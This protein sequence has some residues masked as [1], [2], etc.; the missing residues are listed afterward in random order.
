MTNLQNPLDLADVAEMDDPRQFIRNGG[1]SAFQCVVILICVLIQALDGFNVLVVAYT[2]SP[3]AH[4]WNL[5]PSN[6]GVLFSA[7]PLGMA[8]GFTVI[9]PLGDR[10]GRKPILL[11]SL[12]AM[13]LGMLAS[14]FARNVSDLLAMRALTGVGIA[15]ALASVN[16]IVAEYSSEKRR[17]LAI[18]LMTIGYPLG[19]MLGG[20]LSIYL[21]RVF[22]WRAVYAFGASVALALLPCVLVW[23]PE[24][25][26]YLMER[27]PQNALQKTNAI[28]RKMGHPSLA[29]LP[30]VLLR[31]NVPGANVWTIFKQPYLPATLAASSAYF[32]VSITCYFLLN[33][34]PRL[35]TERGFSLAA[36]ISGSLLMSIAGIVGGLFFGFYGSVLGARRLG[37]AIMV[38]LFVATVLFG[39]MPGDKGALSAEC[40]A[41]GFCLFTS[42]TVLLAVVPMAFPS[43]VRATGVGFAMGVGR[44][45]SILGPLLAGMLIANGWARVEYCIVMAVP[46]LVAAASLYWV[47][48]PD[49][50]GAGYQETL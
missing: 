23:L 31:D 36:G 19:A 21:I 7:G 4:E 38:G 34:T 15:C 50:P 46:M 11:L 13:A 10:L 40:F 43:F 32:T 26:D 12:C 17:S 27:R 16:I 22:G 24:S 3:V 42:F 35:L 47:R 14:A 18:S 5:S 37:G 9:M 45:G 25:I 2:A 6:L 49:V 30:A 28:I 8:F 39:I 20:L 41:V 1:L 48:L 33:W 29:R 44:A